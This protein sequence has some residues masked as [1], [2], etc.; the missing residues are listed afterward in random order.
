MRVQQ[1]DAPPPL[2]PKGPC[3]PA[4][5]WDRCSGLNVW[6][7]VGP[8]KEVRRP[9]GTDFLRWRI[10]EMKSSNN[11]APCAPGSHGPPAYCD[12]LHSASSSRTLQ[13]I[14]GQLMLFFLLLPNTLIDCHVV[15]TLRENKTATSNLKLNYAR[16][17]AQKLVRWIVIML[18][19]TAVVFLIVMLMFVGYHHQCYLRCISTTFVFWLFSRVFLWVC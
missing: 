10:S 4:D 9:D 19:E 3:L 7:H 16:V 12:S 14:L 6:V 13:L 1:D 2:F 18:F 17:I 8:L 15:L 5:H 11:P